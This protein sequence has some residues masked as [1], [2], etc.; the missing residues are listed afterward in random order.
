MYAPLPSETARPLANRLRPAAPAAGDYP[1]VEHPDIATALIYTRDDEFFTP[2][3]QRYVA[4]DLL[5]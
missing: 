1:L 5:G 4:R 2:E 3:W